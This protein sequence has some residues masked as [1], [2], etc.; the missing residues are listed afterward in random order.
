MSQMLYERN[1][2]RRRVFVHKTIRTTRAFRRNSWEF[3]W[4]QGIGLGVTVSVRCLFFNSNFTLELDKRD[5]LKQR[6]PSEGKLYSL[7]R[8]VVGERTLTLTS[9]H[10]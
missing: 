2:Q 4:P 10:D 7:R 1:R 6:R 8:T 5:S 9:C 3:E